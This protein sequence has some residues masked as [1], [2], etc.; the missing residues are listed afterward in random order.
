MKKIIKKIASVKEHAAKKKAKITKAAAPVS[1]GIKKQYVKAKPLCKVTFRLPKEAAPEASVVTV[2]GDFNDWNADQII[3]QKLKNGD[4][5]VTVELPRDREYR[6]KYRID[7]VRWE[8]D[9]AADKYTKNEY[10]SD[11]SV[12]IV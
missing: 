6:F 1:S 7:S 5:K 11:D 10:G 2:A 3:M 12:V 8:N 9:W 4:F